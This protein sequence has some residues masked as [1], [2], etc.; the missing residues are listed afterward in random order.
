VLSSEESPLDNEQLEFMLRQLTAVRGLSLENPPTV[1]IVDDAKFDSTA[2][3][4]V[5]SRKRYLAM[6]EAFGF[7]AKG[8][9]Q[10]DVQ[11]LLHHL[12][13]AYY[14]PSANRISVRR[15]QAA[16]SYDRLLIATHELEHALQLHN[17][18]LGLPLELPTDDGV[19]ATTALLEGDAMFADLVY[20]HTYT[21]ENL[22]SLAW[23]G[24]A[25]KPPVP[26]TVPPYFR[27]TIRFKNRGGFEFVSQLFRTGGFALVDRALKHPPQSSEQVLHIE[28]YL[29]GKKP[30]DIVLPPTAIP[31]GYSIVASGVLGEIGARSVLEVCGTVADGSADAV[32]WAGDH[33][34]VVA[35]RAGKTHVAWLTA[36]DEEAAASRYAAV[37]KTGT[38]CWGDATI[39]RR[40]ERVVVLRGFAPGERAALVDALHAAPREAATLKPPLGEVVL[41]PKEP[42]PADL[43]RGEYFLDGNTFRHVGL[44]FEAA[45]P[46]GFRHASVDQ[47]LVEISRRQAPE[48]DA[49]LALFAGVAPEREAERSM[50]LARIVASAKKWN[51]ALLL[52]SVTQPTMALGRGNERVWTVDGT[53]H[54]IFVLVIPE[55][56]KRTYVIAGYWGDERARAYYNEWLRSFRRTRPLSCN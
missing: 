47:F 23:R 2:Q 38:A 37:L 25:N 55:C 28:K 30:I 15:S 11:T 8:G 32:D 27:N 13:Q 24:L 53:P 46:A 43:D 9:L 42:L 16:N 45:I 10:A 40:G 7:V 5:D 3:V 22:R 44:G 36:W 17:F 4:D 51:Q 35:D 29:A 6:V 34:F 31:N 48:M 54:K 56:E 21:H 14:D 18:S 12:V 52:S 20:Q 1:E 19:L 33:F 50:E 49:L 26:P 41:A 39:E